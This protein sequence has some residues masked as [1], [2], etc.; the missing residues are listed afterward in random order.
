LKAPINKSEKKPMKKQEP[1][2]LKIPYLND[3]QL[4]ELKKF[5]CASTD[6]EELV[7]KILLHLIAHSER[8]T[9]ELHFCYPV[10]PELYNEIH[11]MNSS[12]FNTQLSK[13]VRTQ[14]HSDMWIMANKAGP[15]NKEELLVWLLPGIVAHPNVQTQIQKI[16]EVLAIDLRPY[17]K[18]KE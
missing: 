14:L 10:D 5:I 3:R 8:F 4:F 6:C 2:P 7:K 9:K 17:S 12:S 11:N 16:E 1:T 18:N 13:F 15:K